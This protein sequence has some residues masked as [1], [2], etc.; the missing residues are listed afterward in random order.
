LTVPQERRQ[1]RTWRKEAFATLIAVGLDPNRSTLFYQ[2]SVCLVFTWP[3]VLQCWHS[4][5]H[6]TGSPTC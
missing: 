2:S 3:L 6:I 4:A 5:D 1:L